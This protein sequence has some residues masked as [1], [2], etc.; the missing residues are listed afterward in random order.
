[1]NILRVS[2]EEKAR[3]NLAI[4]LQLPTEKCF[5]ERIKYPGK[6]QEKLENKN[7]LISYEL[8]YC[9]E[10]GQKGYTSV[11]R[12]VPIGGQMRSEG[13]IIQI[14]NAENLLIM[15]KTIKIENGF[16]FGCSESLRKEM[17]QVVDFE[18]LRNENENYLGEKMNRS[19][20]RLRMKEDEYALAGEE[21]L[22][23][24]HSGM[25]LDPVLLEKLYDLGRFYQIVDTGTIPPMWGQHN[26]NTNLQVCA[27]NN[28]GLFEEMEV[29]FKYYENKFED[30]RT[31]AKRLFGARGLL[32]SIHCDYDSG[33]LYHFS[34]TYPHYC[35]TGCLGWVYNELWGY[36]LIT[37]D[38]EFLRNRIIPAL[39]E[40]A[41]FYEDYGC[42]RDEDGHSV[43]YPSFSPENPTPYFIKKSKG[44][45]ATGTNSVM[46][47]MI[48]REV[49][50][51]L[52][53]GCREL[54]IEEENIA[55]WERQ[56]KE[57][58]VYLLDEEGGLKEWAWPTIPENYNHRHVSH[59][60][61]LWPGH[62]LTWEKEP[63]LAKAIMISNRKRGH[64]DDS[65]HGIIH[66][67]FSAIRLKDLDETIQNLE[68]LM[69]HG[70]VTRSLNTNHFPYAM[71]FP[72]LQGAMP[73]ILIE[74]C[75]CS[76]PGVI[77]FLPAMPKQL[78]VGRIEGIW[79]YTWMK[80]ECM[81]WNE[82]EIRAELISNR[83]QKVSLK[84]GKGPADFCINGEVKERV[85]TQMSV[86]FKTGEKVLL[87][88]RRSCD[89]EGENIIN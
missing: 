59:H 13:K 22:Q 29:Y 25:E 15:A 74:M 31:N 7:G 58:P 51:N 75:V 63:E 53:T 64:Q 67:L 69:N 68:Y 56:R 71:R 26:I 36:Y 11:I 49:L 30:F 17:Q 45:S 1:M 24:I 16:E 43:F 79:L 83:D 9:P 46:D 21:L 37:G 19:V 80:L 39:K 23:R 28:T 89:A 48:C 34:F 85:K 10:Y 88:I 42:D 52:I 70:Y 81:E 78:Q 3:I 44:L 77:E 65:A 2:A 27:G 40:I 6:C 61:A 73:A 66:R 33:L 41:L 54:G 8:A 86:L 82:T 20:I 84:Y 55:H 50:D 35:W 57:L 72:D 18:I 76:A 87:E 38:R 62:D 5:D 60:Y 47:V 14:E 4:E 32:A 12:I